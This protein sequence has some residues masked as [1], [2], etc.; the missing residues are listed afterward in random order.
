MSN[1]YS[2]IFVIMFLNSFLMAYSYDRV[3]EEDA[4]N[5][6]PSSRLNYR[7]NQAQQ[8][9]A[10]NNFQHTDQDSADD[11]YDSVAE[12]LGRDQ[13]LTPKKRIIEFKRNSENNL[14]S[15]RK[16]RMNRAKLLQLIK[17]LEHY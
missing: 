17:L 4:E 5:N 15:L 7:L 1:I 13:D 2:F 10:S 12:L 8:H 14:N 3:V 16:I 6:W 9:Q 11:A